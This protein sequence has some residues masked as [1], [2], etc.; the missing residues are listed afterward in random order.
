MATNETKLI[1]NIETLLRGL[2]KT[3]KGLDAI[4][5]K[6]K[7][8]GKGVGGATAVDKSIERNQRK[9]KQAEEALQRQRSTALIAENNRQQR[10][11]EALQRQRS[12]AAIAE[13]KR[14]QAAQ[15]AL[16]NKAFQA[17]QLQRKAQQRAAES[18]QRQRSAS[19][20]AENKREA[21]ARSAI[22]KSI[23]RNREKQERAA[24]S[25]QRQRSASILANERN[26]QRERERLL[27]RS[28]RAQEA[29]TREAIAQENRRNA[30]VQSLQR[31]RSA[32]LIANARA[33]ERA[34][35]EAFSRLPQLDAHIR[36]FRRLQVEVA[37]TDAKFV[38]F[39]NSARSFGQGLIT[40]GIGFTA[41]LTV[42]L[43]A[44]GR[45]SLEAA[46]E[47]DSLKRG[48][49]AIV[50]S[51]SE[52][53][54]QLGRL[55][56]IAKLPGIGFQEAIQGS[57]R[58]QAVGFSAAE[59]EKSLVQ[60]S[61]AIALFG[62]GREE[63][64][65][66][67][68]QLGQMRAAGKVLNQDLRPI[69]QTAPAVAQAMREAFGTVTAGDIDKLGLSSEEFLDIL[70]TQLAKLPRAAAGARNTFE[71]FRDTLFRVSATIGDAIIPVMTTLINI[72]EPVAEAI[73]RVFKALPGPLQVT[74]VL[75]G[76]LLAAAGPLV[77]VVGFASLGFGRL[78]VAIG[79]MGV[80]NVGATFSLRAL[81]ASLVH[82]NAAALTTIARLTG[83]RTATIAAGGPWLKLATAIAVVATAFATTADASEELNAAS[84]E[85]IKATQDRIKFIESEGRFLTEL[86]DGVAKTAKEQERLADLYKALGIETQLHI[87]SIEGEANQTEA[88]RK[89]LEKLAKV[90]Q[91]RLRFQGAGLAAKFAQELQKLID[92][93][94][95]QLEVEKKIN[96]A[97][98]SGFRGVINVAELRK[99]YEEL[100]GELAEQKQL[101]EQG[102]AKL[103]VYE[104]VSGDSAENAF[105]LSQAID[106]TK[107]PLD[108]L[109][110]GLDKYTVK[111]DAAAA[112]TARF[113]LELDKVT[114]DFTTVGKD[115]EDRFDA[116][117]KNILQTERGT[118]NARRALE[119]YL[120]MFP[121]LEA[122]IEN[123]R[124]TKSRGDFFD[125]LLTEKGGRAS[126][127]TSLR[128]AQEG[129][130]KALA[131]VAQ[132]SADQLGTIERLKND[133]LLQENQNAYDLQLK[134]YTEFLREKA[135]LT[136]ANL[137]LEISAQRLAIKAA[138][139]E[140]KRE[141]E[142]STKAGI[143][144]AERERALEGAAEANARAITATT[145]LRELEA[146]RAAI[147]IETRHLNAVSLREQQKEV[148]ALGR[149]LDEITG[150]EREAADAAVDEKFADALRE[151]ANKKNEVINNL[152]DARADAA[153]SNQLTD[154]YANADAIEERLK[155]SVDFTNRGLEERGRLLKEQAAIN[156]RIVELQKQ[157]T[158]AREAR[159]A[160]ATA[161]INA[162]IK[163]KEGQRDQLKAV[164]ALEEAER[165]INRAKELQADLEDRLTLQVDLHGLKQ[166]EALRQ[167]L[168]GEKLVVA[169]IERQRVAIQAVINDLTRRGLAV[170]VGLTRFIEQIDIAKGKLS[171]LTFT[172]QFAIAEEEF[173]RLQDELEDSI[174]NVERAVRSRDIAEIQGAVIIRRLNGEKVDALEA[175]LALLEA[176]AQ[177]SGDERLQRRATQAGQTVKDIKAEADAVKDLDKQL[178]SVA[179]DSFSDSL[180]QLFKDLRDNTQ[181]ATEDILNFFNNILN[182]VNDFIAENLAREI[183]ESLF[184]D[185]A[186]G[187]KG[188]IGGL[189]DAIKG[190]FGLGKKQAELPI[191]DPAL[192]AGVRD[193]AIAGASTTAATALTT[194]GTTVGATLTTAGATT[195]AALTTGGT[196]LSTSLVTAGTTLS[197]GI[198]SAATAFGATV[199]AAGTAFATSVAGASAAEDAESVFDTVI[200]TDINEKGLANP[201][202]ANTAAIITLTD[203]V[204]ALT[205]IMGGEEA[206]PA[207]SIK[208]PVGNLKSDPIGFI[209]SIGSVI[210][211]L[212]KGDQAGG[213][214]GQAGNVGGDVPLV[215]A[216]QGTTVIDAINIASDLLAQ[217][218]NGINALIVAI[219]GKDAIAGAGGDAKGGT[220][221]TIKTIGSAAIGIIGSLFKGEEEGEGDGGGFLGGLFGTEAGA[222]ARQGTNLIDALN[223]N[224]DEV[225]KNTAAL[226]ANTDAQGSSGGGDL[227][228]LASLFAGAA[229]GRFIP[230]TQGGRIIRVAEGG[231]DE[232][233]LTTD[234]KHALRQ[235]AILREFLKRTRGLSG[236]FRAQPEEF[237]TG[238]FISARE[239]EAQILGT[240]MSSRSPSMQSMVPDGLVAEGPSRPSVN[241][242]NINQIDRGSM[243]RGYLRS[244]EGT[245]DIINVISENA[246]DVGRRIGVK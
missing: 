63:L 30:A 138:E 137:E 8:V 10:A 205:K 66:V 58:L 91:E 95:E 92:K 126:S 197:T 216:E 104:E 102:A 190:A 1:I 174:A 236:H 60:F 231:H 167:R 208:D 9:Q 141:T 149:E 50:G 87:K 111:A 2:D 244:A 191:P 223:F 93:Q 121:E 179:I 37:A 221:D 116:I 48:L 157:L 124:G 71:N 88:L 77:T 110:S 198:A 232:A 146:Q 118:V 165:R 54:V 178:K 12:A 94:N 235:V 154:F 171:K 242:R 26:L 177:K 169:E 62:G 20:I 90:E 100:N 158:A 69:I 195:A 56:E 23:A 147:A 76:A 170:P 152:L 227:S 43:V 153:I 18:L 226:K 46:V 51:A 139:D 181:S 106:G 53:N 193:T 148:R 187:K 17:D 159:G 186:S 61:N 72:V 168:E 240:L 38:K 125:E 196:T 129:L 132:A 230:S 82:F 114:V 233:V 145:K 224:S 182:R 194:A 27:T 65:R 11:V 188:G 21:T 222:G 238:G 78:A 28:R 73:A 74:V 44:V 22:D 75:F 207:S 6:L 225:N 217:V 173:T 105:K 185:P 16:N 120:K 180:G 162:Q 42:P 136:Q 161:A 156:A 229:S 40:L 151:L 99:R 32:A 245:R 67:I 89:E 213:V 150:K 241:V 19:I 4:D 142:T 59:S 5:R 228:G 33:D 143:P 183:T 163:E 199:S 41:A 160:S 45:A 119:G 57:I 133:S 49:T 192:T 25:L 176:I 103:K 128:N 175:Q 36:D 7:S 246:P 80:A 112:S 79:Q 164:N 70:I 215:T 81:S 220:L 83:L 206:L 243:V 101:V 140:A 24:E 234:P 130:A 127:G 131:D 123:K 107:S 98:E 31:Q 97:R 13:V 204:N 115:L 211:G 68:L 135:R 212:F 29:A 210:A 15:T 239:A 39:G 200:K 219:A 96:T 109:L 64:D 189:I 184:P 113:R 202:E 52:A 108:T 86:Q 201:T 122:V 85:Q 172:E 3:L 209:S 84:E 214:D 134:S 117:V 55:T 47:M 144:P 203:S 34:G 155:T 166:S 14:V 237:A 35:R 218:V